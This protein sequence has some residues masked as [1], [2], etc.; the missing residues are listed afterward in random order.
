[1]LNNALREWTVALGHES[2][3]TQQGVIST[4]LKNT[5][6]FIRHVPALLRPKSKE[7]VQ[8]LVR[9]AR[10]HKVPIYP[11]STGH[12]WG[13]GT[14]CPVSE[15]SVLVDLSDMN[16]IQE[17]DEELGVVTV[18]PG[19]TQLLLAKF[20]KDRNFPF[21]TPTTHAGPNCSILGNALEKG[22][23]L[24]PIVDHFSAV[25]SMDVVLPN[26]EL[27]QSPFQA[28]G[29]PKVPGIYK[30]GLG[31]YTDGLFSQSNLGIVV[32]MTLKLAP[33][34][35]AIESFYFTFENQAQLDANVVAVRSILARCRGQVSGIKIMN[36]ERVQAMRQDILLKENGQVS[37]A[38]GWIGIGVIY[39]ELPL[40]KGIKK[41]ISSALK[42]NC[43]RFGFASLD[44]VRLYKRM[45]EL[46]PLPFLS[47]RA[48]ELNALEKVLE[49]FHGIPNERDLQ[50]AYLYAEKSPKVGEGLD[51]ARDGCGLLWYS[52][53]IEMKPE[54][55]RAYIT[56]VK[57]TCAD[58]GI[59]PLIAF[60]GLSDT[61]FE[62]LVPLLF[63]P[64]LELE[65]GKACYEQ[66]FKR[67]LEKGFAPYRMSSQFMHLLWQK[68]CLHWQLLH[69][70]KILL[71]PDQIIAPG[72]Y[73]PL[74]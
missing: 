62:C 48:N 23:G 71:D 74:I 45:L 25:L 30:W 49:I 34:P 55:V 2:V 69:R 52:S 72:R 22:F 27:L 42:P 29:A 65:K 20:I 24:T 36:Q 38:A 39:T 60:T 70:L 43:S 37:P 64:R 41:C 33:K 16:H 28:L 63:D 11:F 8:E 7:Q 4:R 56:F 12:N 18:Q 40:L 10:R 53:I 46:F 68:P 50:L 3:I 21:I 26:G 32:S 15:D 5:E 58:F 57:E 73:I 9:I 31:P 6:G 44:K 51:P 14:A 17:F 1:M 61:F 35:E 67:G 47:N 54:T 59:D 19:V 13:Y 66:L